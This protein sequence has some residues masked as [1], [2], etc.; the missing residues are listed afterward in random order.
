MNGTVILFK[1]SVDNFIYDLFPAHITNL[2]TGQRDTDL[3][4]TEAVARGDE[5]LFEFDNDS[6]IYDSYS[7]SQDEDQR[8]P[9]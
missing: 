8:N 5:L 1:T 2:N 3:D 9:M 6:Q 4:L 7:I